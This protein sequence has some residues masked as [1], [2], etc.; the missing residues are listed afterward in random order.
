MTLTV[1]Q[2]LWRLRAGNRRFASGSARG[3]REQTPSGAPPLAAVVVCSDLGVRPESLFGVTAGELVVLQTP[4]IR[5]G[6]AEATA[7]AMAREYRGVGL[8]IVLGHTACP[9]VQTMQA[10]GGTGLFSRLVA[11]EVGEHR[12]DACDDCESYLV[13]RMAG[14]LREL[15]VDCGDL[16]VV[17]AMLDSRSRTV[18]FMDAN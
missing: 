7:C 17:G 12:H 18:S 15:L 9:T 14:R 11:E 4:G 8:A 16:A 13:A 1:P 6:L 10:G 3:R 2:T 5:V